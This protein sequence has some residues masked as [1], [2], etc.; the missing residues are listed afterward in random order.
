M[1]RSRVEESA[2]N[3]QTDEIVTNINVLGSLF[4]FQPHF[5]SPTVTVPSTYIS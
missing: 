1:H 3:L 5:T 4:V 2:E